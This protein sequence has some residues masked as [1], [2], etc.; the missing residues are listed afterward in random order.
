MNINWGTLLM[1]VWYF[2]QLQYGK[3][4]YN[5]HLYTFTPY[6]YIR[7]TCR[8]HTITC[9]IWTTLV[10]IQIECFLLFSHYYIKYIP[11]TVL[12]LVG[13][14]LVVITLQ[15]GHLVIAT[16]HITKR[17]FLGTDWLNVLIMWV[18]FHWGSTI[19]FYSL[20]CHM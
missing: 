14:H 20:H 16:N 12:L 17:V 1:I 13:S 5:S 19:T 8:K 4:F 9:F 6:M 3:R 15:M 10:N 18:T 2:T 7:R 11:S